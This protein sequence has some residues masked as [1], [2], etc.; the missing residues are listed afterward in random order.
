MITDELTALETRVR[1]Y[2][3]L[4]DHVDQVKRFQRAGE[5]ISGHVNRL[6]PLLRVFAT[7]RAAGILDAVPGD[8]ARAVA[9]KAADLLQAFRDRPTAVLDER[10]FTPTAL[11]EPITTLAT[12]LEAQLRRAWGDY[13]SA[14]VPPANADVLE[15]LAP[16][17]R[18]EVARIRHL[19]S[20]LD[21]LRLVLPETQAVIDDLGGKVTELQQAWQTLDGGQVPPSVLAFLKAASSTGAALALLTD[22]VRRWLADHGIDRSFTIRPAR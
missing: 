9:Q 19:S 20:Q 17:F 3:Q 5:L 4:R 11:N 6:R 8:A 1:E 18:S 13:V 7:L 16:T 12:A 22:E 21:A 10:P 2:R 14:R 15:V